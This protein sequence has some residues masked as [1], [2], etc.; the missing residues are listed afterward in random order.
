M[1]QKIEQR[2]LDVSMSSGSL[3][4]SRLSKK[5]LFVQCK[6]LGF[7]TLQLGGEQKDCAL[8]LE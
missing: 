8:D 3:C 5:G 4:V 6:I 1:V 7:V 2:F